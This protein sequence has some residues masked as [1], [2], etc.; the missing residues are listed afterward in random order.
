MKLLESKKNE[1]AK[2][3]NVENVTFLKSNEVVLVH[4][5]IFNIIIFLTY[6][7]NFVPNCSK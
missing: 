7:K 6:F 3:K 1:I 5:N 4:S 2:D